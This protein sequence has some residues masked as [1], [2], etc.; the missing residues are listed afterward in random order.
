[1]LAGA[2]HRLAPHCGRESP[3]AELASTS[4]P[5]TRIFVTLPAASGGSQEIEAASARTSLLQRVSE[6]RRQV[7]EGE[8]LERARPE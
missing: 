2:I 7:Q 8:A 4:L 3:P 1:M 5:P 6:R